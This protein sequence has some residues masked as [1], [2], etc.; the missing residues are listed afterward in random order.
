MTQVT[1]DAIKKS[2][3]GGELGDDE[4]RVLANVM[5]VLEL[6]D[7]EVLVS[8]GE[9]DTTLFLLVSGGL[10]VIDE[11]KIIYRMKLGEIAGTR[12]FVDR[13]PRKATLQAIGD[14]VVYGMQ[15][16]AFEALIDTHPRVVFKV[17][18]ALFCITHTNLMRMNTESS[19]LTN[20]ITRGGGRR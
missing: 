5:T 16:D 9:K 8:H 2:T 12:A 13:Q 18:R 10:A 1:C 11:N 19:H 7:G 15:P 3:L 6:A 14:T 4:C 20:Y 17:M